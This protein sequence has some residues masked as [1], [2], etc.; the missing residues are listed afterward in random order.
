MGITFKRIERAGFEEV[1]EAIDLNCGFHAF[2]A[3]HSTKLGPA[4]GGLR[5]YPYSTSE[6]ALEDA[7]K[8]SQA[9]SYKAALAGTG[10]GG[11][12]AVLI[13][14]HKTKEHLDAFAEVLNFLNGR[15]IVAEDVGSTTHDMGMLKEKSPYVVGT[16]LSKGSGDP[17][18][19][20][21][22]GLLASM[23]VL[24]NG[25]LENKRIAIQGLGSVGMR[26]AKSLFWEGALLQIYELLPQKC[27]LVQR[28]YEAQI[29][30][31]NEIFSEPCDFFAPCA[32][33]GILN[34]TI[35][36]QLRC[37]YVV[38]SANNQLATPEDGYRLHEK[39]IL[40]LPDFIVNS[41]GLINVS[42]EL[43]SSYSPRNARF[44]TL[45]LTDRVKAIIKRAENEKCPPEILAIEQAK[46]ILR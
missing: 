26:L 27:L 32:L 28:K 42:C 2:V 14:K 45:Q 19:F 25:S 31:E 3:I 46:E 7:L 33:G 43:A 12:K 20:T 24:A 4:L 44:K 23:K 6:Q 30:K 1:I 22:F 41:G 5:I 34:E 17:S 11:G 18:H 10:T 29:L 40:Y 37:K 13:T 8:L 16:D 35:I 39:G 38:G 21:V 9:M 36:S 15:F